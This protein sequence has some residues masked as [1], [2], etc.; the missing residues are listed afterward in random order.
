MQTDSSTATMDREVIDP[1]QCNG[2]RTLAD[3]TTELERS[4]AFLGADI[5]AVKSKRKTREAPRLSVWKA[6]GTIMAW[7]PHTHHHHMCC[8]RV[9][10]PAQVR[11]EVLGGEIWFEIWKSDGEIWGRL[12]HL[13]SKA[14]EILGRISG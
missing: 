13:A 9:A 8:V 4:G 14:L 6:R 7:S 3:T 10:M 2:A 1:G 11:F 5:S 12:F